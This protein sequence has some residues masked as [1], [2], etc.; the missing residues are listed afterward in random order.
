MKYLL[1]TD[2]TAAEVEAQ[3]GM[4][5]HDTPIGALVEDRKPVNIHESMA[6][7]DRALYPTQCTC[8]MHAIIHRPN[9]PAWAWIT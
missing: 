3:T 4:R 2:A 5:G 9:C 6:I 7:I 1:V 8:D